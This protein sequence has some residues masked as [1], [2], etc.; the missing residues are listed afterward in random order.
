MVLTLALD[1]RLVIPGVCGV[2]QGDGHEIITAKAPAQ[3][4][5]Y[6]LINLPECLSRPNTSRLSDLEPSSYQFKTS[7]KVPSCVILGEQR[8]R[9]IS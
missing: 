6:Q 5:S 3:G 1:Y 9:R 8:D 4:N 7:A 2:Y